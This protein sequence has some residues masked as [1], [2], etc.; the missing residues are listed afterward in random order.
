MVHFVPIIQMEHVPSA[1]V[2]IIIPGTR[3]RILISLFSVGINVPLSDFFATACGY[4]IAL[5]ARSPNR[6]S[7]SRQLLNLF[8]VF[9]PY[10]LVFLIQVFMHRCEITSP[11]LFLLVN[12]LSRCVTRLLR[13]VTH[14]FPRRQLF[15]H[16]LTIPVLVSRALFLLIRNQR[17][18]VWFGRCQARVIVSSWWY[19]YFLI[20]VVVSL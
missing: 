18:W 15:T 13:C 14:F 17:H 19:R 11:L 12:V 3:S 4:V 20:V 2:L 1:P 9:L 7:I 6:I 16:A 10:R 5:T 8:V